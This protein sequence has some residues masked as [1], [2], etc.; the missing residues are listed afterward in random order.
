[1]T[2]AP[3][4]I[5]GM[6]TPLLECRDISVTFGLPRTLGDL[7]GGRPPQRLH[8]LRNVSLQVMPGE[9][10]GIVGES[11]CGKSTLGRTI[12]GLQA[13]DSG[14]LL[15]EGRPLPRNGERRA[16]ARNIQMVFQDPYASL[17]PRMTIGQM[18]DEVLLV[19]EMCAGAAARRQRVE[20]LLL[21][22]GLAPALKDRLPHAISGGQR[23]RVSIARALAVEPRLLIA[24]EP[25]SALDASVRAQIINLLEDLRAKLGIAIL[26]VAHDLNVVRHISDRVA[27][28]YLGEVLETAHGDTLFDAPR[29]PYTQ[30]LLAA[31]PLPDPRRRNVTPGITGELPDPLHPP[32]GCS[33]S[34]R[35]SYASAACTEARPALQPCG[36]ASAVRCIHPRSPREVLP[37]PASIPS[38]RTF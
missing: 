26:F 28:M 32:P 9:I 12:A 19:H 15:W 20:D 30:G 8:A 17:N 34:A 25:V 23:Q 18:L 6:H 33:F 4:P 27:V 29:H 7:L 13:P 35:C 21:M 38:S 10:V 2:T 37:V 22:V 16:R 24:D 11:G 31:I 5:A 36:I 3:S 1:M 14:E